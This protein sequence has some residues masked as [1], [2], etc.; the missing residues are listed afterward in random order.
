LTDSTIRKRNGALAISRSELVRRLAEVSHLTYVRQKNRD[1]GVPL[2]ELT[3]EVTDHDRER[4]EDIVAELER[5]GV[6]GES[7]AAQA[8]EEP[9]PAP[10][11]EPTESADPPPRSRWKGQTVTD[12]WGKPIAKRTGS[13]R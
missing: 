7:G 6:Y 1:H 4:A 12:I 5:L 8:P 3:L 9:G 10:A 13:G 11:P 2:N